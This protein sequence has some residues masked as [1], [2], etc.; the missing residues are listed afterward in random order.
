MHGDAVKKTLLALLLAASA[1]QLMAF[2]V[3]R[4]R[5]RPRFPSRGN[6]W[7]QFDDD[8]ED[9]DPERLKLV[10]PD[11]EHLRRIWT[12]NLPE[13]ADGSPIYVS[14]DRATGPDRD[15]LIVTT[16]KGRT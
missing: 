8:P 7:L 9:N 3:L 2:P 5:E 15:L 16:M 12:A 6:E 11:V 13:T 14:A 1:V 4:L 10:L